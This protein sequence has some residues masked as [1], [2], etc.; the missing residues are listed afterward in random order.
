[1]QVPAPQLYADAMR[2]GDAARG[3]FDGDG[4]AARAKL[5][6]EARAAVAA[7]SLRVTTRLLEVVSVLLAGQR[8]TVLPP[9]PRDLAPVPDR[10]GG[11]AR[12]IVKGVRDLYLRTFADELGEHEAR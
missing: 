12:V 4:I 10:L 8:G 6:P 5:R 3:Y 1:M 9:R 7:E 2:L 11:P